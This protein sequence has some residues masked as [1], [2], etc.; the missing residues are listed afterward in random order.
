MDNDQKFWIRIWTI[1]AVTILALISGVQ[2]YYNS[3]N[4]KLVAMVKAGADPIKAMCAMGDLSI[5]GRAAVCAT[6]A[7]APLMQFDTPVDA[8]VDPVR[9]EVDDKSAEVIV[10]A[11]Q[12]GTLIGYQTY[13]KVEQIVVDPNYKLM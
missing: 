5:S 2:L 4:D 3:Q 13:P 12:H 1:L 11:W 6:A 8:P 10:H 9:Y 7:S